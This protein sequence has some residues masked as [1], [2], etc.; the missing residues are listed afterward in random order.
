M[1]GRAY[2]FVQAFFDGNLH[3]PQHVL[4]FLHCAFGFTVGSGLSNGIVFRHR[5]H[6]L[7]CD[8]EMIESGLKHILK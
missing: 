4:S 6:Q 7:V 5:T 2:L 8:R 3:G 1:V